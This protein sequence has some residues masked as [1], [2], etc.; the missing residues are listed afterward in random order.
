MYHIVL[1][2]EV[3][4]VWPVYVAEYLGLDGVKEEA[5]EEKRAT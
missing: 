5:V 1:V 3:E 4:V 2:K